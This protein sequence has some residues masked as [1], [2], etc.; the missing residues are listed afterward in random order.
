MLG[1]A[2]AH[3]FELPV[4]MSLQRDD[5][6]VVQQ[7]HRGW[8]KFAFV[9]GVQVIALLATAF[10]ARR[11]RRVLIPTI[12]AIVFVLGAQVLFW[13]YTHPVNVA[14][15]NWTAQTDNWVQLRRQWEYSHLAGAGLQ[16]LAM[17]CLIVAV[18]SR[19]PTRKRS[20]HYY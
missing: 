12:L 13:T 1:P 10:L 4:K 19:L 2:L 5:Y 6:F 18:V 8:D 3:A 15:A 9:L 17:A 20:Y 14:T 16:V 11:Q 7:I